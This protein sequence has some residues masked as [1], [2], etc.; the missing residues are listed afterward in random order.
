MSQVTFITLAVNFHRTRRQEVKEEEGRKQDE[1]RKEGAGQDRV[2]TETA[3]WDGK[4]S[5][6]K[7]DH[8]DLLSVHVLFFF[9][10]LIHSVWILY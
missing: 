5:G 7:R 4:G 1:D 6:V 8:E 10:A 9:P 2:G 3:G